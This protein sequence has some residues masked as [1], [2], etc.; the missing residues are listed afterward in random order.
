MLIKQSIISLIF[1]FSFVQ[2]ISAAEVVEFSS[3]DLQGNVHSIEQYRGK[4]VVVNFW[5]TFCGPCIREMPELSAFHNE[6]KDDDA[7]VIGINQ[8]EIP[9]KLLANFTRNL[10]VSFPSLKVP[11]EQATPFGRVTVLPTTFIINPQGELVARQPGAISL[12]AL[13]DYI[14]RKKQQ[15][16]QEEFKKAHGLGKT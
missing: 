8:E 1:T 12:K 4:W 11:F 6:R 5:G 14:A 3:K 2:S 7:V 9:A 16:L 10:K 15:A 13:E